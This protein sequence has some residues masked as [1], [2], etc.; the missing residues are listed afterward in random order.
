[1]AEVLEL[2]A[3]WATV[4]IAAA[5]ILVGGSACFL[6]WR[7]IVEMHRSSEDRAKDHREERAKPTCAVTRRPWTKGFAITRRR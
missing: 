1:M 5:T 4:A 2:I 3:A 6:I 7:G